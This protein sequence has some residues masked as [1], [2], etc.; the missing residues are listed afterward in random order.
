MENTVNLTLHV[1]AVTLILG[2]LTG[3]DDLKAVARDIRR[4]L[5]NSSYVVLDLNAFA[6]QIEADSGD[7]EMVVSLFAVQD[8]PVT[9]VYGTN[10]GSRGKV[11]GY[12]RSRK[13]DGQF[14][15][16]QAAAKEANRDLTAADY[17]VLIDAEGPLVK[18]EGNPQIGWYP[19]QA[20]GI[21]AR[22]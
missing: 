7:P 5:G 15:R 19:G 22:P 6:A 20:M 10:E 13:A 21:L 2:R 17:E 12:A 11:V 3:D 4:Q 18:W 16:A 8:M 1:S 9:S 14:R